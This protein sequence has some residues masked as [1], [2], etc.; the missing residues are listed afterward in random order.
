MKILIIGQAPPANPQEYP[1]STTMLYDWLK[2]VGVTKEQAQ[3]LFEFEAVGD[4]FPGFDSSGHKK[5]S[6]QMMDE[7]WQN[8]LGAKVKQAEK[9]W[10]LG[11]VASNYLQDKIP[12]D[13]KVLQTIHPS[14]RNQAI[15]GQMRDKILNQI[16]NFLNT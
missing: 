3:D 5:P 11:G 13:K 1:Y 15:F 16:K 4:K 14:T 12:L 2:E 8:T 7:H 9:I 10:V 6:A